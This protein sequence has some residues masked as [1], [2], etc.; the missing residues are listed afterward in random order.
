M[1]LCN[2]SFASTNEREGSQIAR[3]AVRALLDGGVKVAFVT[4]MFDLADGLHRQQ[5]GTALS[6]RT[7]RRP[8]GER[9]YK[10][11][12]GAPLPTSHGED[13]YHKV[14]GMNVEATQAN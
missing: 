2:E 6:L 7:E 4:H 5:L 12:P 14:F 3:Q 11:S 1:L 13:S 9:S 8:G 10:L